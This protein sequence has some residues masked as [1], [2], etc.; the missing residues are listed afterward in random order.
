MT[1]RVKVDYRDKEAKKT[2]EPTGE[3]AYTY[4]TAPITPRGESYTEFYIDKLTLSYSVTTS[5]Q[6]LYVVEH[7]YRPVPVKNS[8]AETVYLAARKLLNEI[9]PENATQL[10]KAEL[11]F[12]Y[13][14]TNIAYD[15]NAVAITK[16]NASVWPE[17]DAFFLEGVFLQKKA[18]CD[19]ISS[20]FSLLCNIEGIP[21]VKVLGPGHAWNRVKINNRW[22]VADA[23]FGN[24]HIANQSYSIADHSQFLISDD[25]KT[26]GGYPGQNY[27]SIVADENYGYFAYKSATCNGRTFDYEI[28]STEELARLLEF[29]SS[30]SSDLSYSTVN[31][32]F[33]IQGTTFDKALA[34]AET[35]LKLRGVTIKNKISYYMNTDT[36]LCK[37]VFLEKKTGR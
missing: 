32:I 34:S 13:L 31:F 3:K 24:L 11:I 35:I 29:V 16:D 2:T 27:L 33:D 4:L 14:I 23:T 6:L 12:N 19:G 37:L 1:I 21:A 20:A 8:P 22:Y 5:N 17:Y 10:E 25:E 28:N 15:D 36:G 9:L 30:L 18:V 7:G 26:K